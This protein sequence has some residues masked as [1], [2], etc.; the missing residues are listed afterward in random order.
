MSAARHLGRIRR[1]R[2]GSPRARSVVTAPSSSHA[3][4][5]GEDGREPGD[6]DQ[7]Q[8][9]LRQA[10]AEQGARYPAR[11]R[12]ARR[13][14]RSP[15]EARVRPRGR[16]PRHKLSTSGPPPATTTPAQ[17]RSPRAAMR[18][19]VIMAFAGG[20]HAYRAAPGRFPTR[21]SR[22]EQ[23]GER[24]RLAGRNVH[25]AEERDE[26]EL[27]DAEPQNCDGDLHDEHRERDEHEVQDE[28]HVHRQAPCPGSR[29]G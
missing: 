18:G 25:L 3:T 11:R 17:R 9:Q 22:D 24:D 5:K 4:M 7:P 26:R 10:V 16:R 14:A 12:G 19:V 1:G 28:R 15:A 8:R 13:T 2:A 27:P 20:P 21:P 29:P 6:D 23:N